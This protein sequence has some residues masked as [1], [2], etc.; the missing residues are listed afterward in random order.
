[1]KEGYVVKNA[2]D[3]KLSSSDLEMINKLTRRNF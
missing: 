1:M 2:K 3:L